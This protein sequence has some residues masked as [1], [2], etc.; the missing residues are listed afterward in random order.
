[1]K[2]IKILIISL[3]VVITSLSVRAIDLEFY[4]PVAVGGGAAQTIEKFAEDYTKL[5]PDVNVK[6]VFT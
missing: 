6:A 3:T 4:F 1:M 5:N 2:V